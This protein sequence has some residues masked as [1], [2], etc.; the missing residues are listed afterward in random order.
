MRPVY[1]RS[2][3]FSR[4]WDKS[5]ETKKKINDTKSQRIKEQLQTRYSILDI[6]EG[7]KKTK[8]DKRALIENLADK[9]EMIT[10][11]EKQTQLW[12]THFETILNKEAPREVEYIPEIDEDLLVN[13]DPP[14]ANEVKAAI[15]NM[16]SGKAPGT[17]G[18]SAEMLKAGGDVIT[19]ILEIFKE[20]WEEE[21]FTRWL[22]DRTYRETAKD[23]KPKPL[24]KLERN[25][26]TV[27]HQ[28]RIQ[29]S[30]PKQNIYSRRPNATQKTG[31]IHRT[32]HDGVPRCRPYVRACMER[33]K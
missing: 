2:L 26:T 22:E 1:F 12:K 3:S 23:R 17:D 21:I 19:E 15:D 25:H 30:D 18:V 32:D 10:S 16:K 28:Q 29:Q 11:V 14:T 20:I 13:M 8:A 24:Q 7:K 6:E 31:Q 27:H 9:A 5:K 33:T 4:Q